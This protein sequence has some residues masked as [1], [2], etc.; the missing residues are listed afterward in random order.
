[1][2]EQIV[3]ELLI[4][5]RELED[6][7]LRIAALV[8]D[9]QDPENVPSV[10]EE[11]DKGPLTDPALTDPYGSAAS[12]AFSRVHSAVR[13]NRRSIASYFYAHLDNEGK[14]LLSL[15]SEPE[16]AHLHE[17]QMDYLENLLSPRLTGQQH[18]EMAKA[19]GIRHDAVSLDPNSLVESYKIYREALMRHL[20]SL[21]HKA[22]ALIKFIDDRLNYDMAWQLMGYAEAHEQRQA[23]LLDLGTRIQYS[24]NQSD[25]LSVILSRLVEGV[26]GIT[27]ALVA[28]LTAEGHLVTEKTNGLVLHTDT[29]S[30]VNS[31]YDALFRAAR[32]EH[33]IWINTLVD[34]T[35]LGSLASERGIRSYA[36]LP[37][38]LHANSREM[39]LVV[40]SKWPGYFLSRGKQF[41]FQSLARE[42]GV[43]I[44]RVSGNHQHEFSPQTLYERQFHRRLLEARKVEMHFQPITGSDGLTLKK[45]ESVARLRDQDRLISPYEF[46]GAFGSN[47]LVMLFEQGIEQMCSTL[48]EVQTRHGDHIGASI[49]LPKEVLDQPGTLN[50]MHEVVQETGLAP[51][52][53]T[54]EILEF[55]ILDEQQALDTIEELRT[56]GYRFA[57]DDLGSGESSLLRMK[58]LL[59]DEVK[60][61][62]GFVRPLVD[63]L[64]HLDYVDTLLRLAQNLKL[65]CVVEGIEDEIILDIIQSLGGVQ[66]QGYGISRPLPRD[67][68]LEWVARNQ[69]SC[70]PEDVSSSIHIPTTLHGWYAR[71]LRRARLILDA[72]PNNP[73]LVNLEVAAYYEN[74]QM[75]H[76]LVEAGLDSHPIFHAHKNFHDAV[77][78]M[79]EGIMRGKSAETLKARVSKRVDELREV[80]LEHSRDRETTVI[81]PLPDM[82]ELL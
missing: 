77:N 35:S 45:F 82:S 62:Q 32:N 9:A 18:R 63:Q 40:Y 12:D 76:Q 47:Q 34:D 72:F 28:A 43:Q 31:G 2:K 71:H 53:I 17:R 13:T 46:L 65:D 81:M 42:M 80:V 74:C 29:E 55:G 38:P 73:D 33:P 4:R 6:N 56:H 27:G 10:Q 20:G 25:L 79:V 11:T 39:I 44:E 58:N 22:P 78:E 16:L 49:N 60:I 1:M 67:R 37:I 66:L 50:Y 51:S 26:P 69:A 75:T 15:L 59:F 24:L 36:S 54:L 61:D 3:Q 52:S 19:A 8:P 68:F 5:I 14:S 70:H 30:S 64:Q 48:L 41:F 23:F 57:M 21:L 7:I